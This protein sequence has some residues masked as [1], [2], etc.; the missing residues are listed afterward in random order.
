[1]SRFVFSDER[2]DY[3]RRRE[4]LLAAEIAL[5]DEVERVAK[6]AAGEFRARGKGG[7]EKRRCRMSP[8]NTMIVHAGGVM[9]RSAE[10]QRHG[11]GT[12]C[13]TEPSAQ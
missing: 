1:M 7:N 3:R 5:K 9:R 11:A 12:A 2:D 8:Q 6:Y 13:P 10:E 4:E